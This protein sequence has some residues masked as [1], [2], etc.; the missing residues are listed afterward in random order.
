MSSSQIERLCA[1]YPE[2][3]VLHIFVDPNDSQLHQLYVNNVEKHNQHILEN[4]TQFNSGFDMFVT[5][6]QPLANGHMGLIDFKVACAAKFY[7]QHRDPQ[8]HYSVNSGFYVYPR[9]SI[10]KSELRLANNVGIIDSGYRGN[11]MGYFDLLPVERRFNP[12]SPEITFGNRITQICAPGL[13]PI[14]VIMVNS[15]EELGETERG[16]GGF[17]STGR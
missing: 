15:R 16:S 12:E 4:H 5:E 8:F 13:Q 9:S 3:M 11:L 7:K 2:F 6:V 17:G 10:S 1:L 14:Y